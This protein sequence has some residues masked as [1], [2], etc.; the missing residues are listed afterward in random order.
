MV[1]GKKIICFL[2]V[3]VSFFPFRIHYLFVSH[4]VSVFSY[5]LNPS[6]PSN[7]ETKPFPNTNTSTGSSLAEFD[8]LDC[9]TSFCSHRHNYDVSTILTESCASVRPSVCG[10]HNF[11][12]FL[13]FWIFEVSGQSIK[14]RGMERMHY[15][16]V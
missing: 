14:G 4:N 13:P 9:P 1:W 8:A 15:E 12:T 2:F 16:F 10:V 6:C 5:I 11:N 7:N 3:S